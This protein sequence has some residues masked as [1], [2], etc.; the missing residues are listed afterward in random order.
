MGHDTFPR[1]LTDQERLTIAVASTYPDR[2]LTV[3]SAIQDRQEF[4]RKLR[5]LIKRINRMKGRPAQPFIYV[6]TV[7][8]SNQGEGGYHFHA[9]IWEYLQAAVLHGF[10]RDLGLGHPHLEPL[11]A[12]RE[13]FCAIFAATSYVL[14][15]HHEVFGSQPHHRHE[16]LPSGARSYLAPQDRTL[17]KANPELLAALKRA[18]SRSV[19]DDAL[20]GATPRFSYRRRPR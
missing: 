8:R 14:G 6:G 3:D 11:P 19:S 1:R 15:Q 12:P 2:T 9:L 10:C 20:I 5:A 18:R 4:H 16:P 17:A 13:N 7:A